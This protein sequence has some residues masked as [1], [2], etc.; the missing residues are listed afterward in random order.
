M[1]ILG[2][3]M[4]ISKGNWW[5]MVLRG[6]VWRLVTAFLYN[7]TFAPQ[8]FALIMQLMFLYQV[9]KCRLSASY[10]DPSAPPLPRRPSTPLPLVSANPHLLSSL[11]F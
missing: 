5:D 7:G 1:Q 11:P 3:L 4:L 2:R 8:P 9:R 6:Q 10:F